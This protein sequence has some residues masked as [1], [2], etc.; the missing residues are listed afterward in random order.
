MT[1]DAC[2]QAG[3]KLDERPVCVSHHYLTPSSVLL[4]HPKHALQILVHY[5]RVHLSLQPGDLVRM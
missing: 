1:A 5:N 4:R 3:C 2:F